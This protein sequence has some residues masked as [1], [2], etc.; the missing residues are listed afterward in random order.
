MLEFE[1]VAREDDFYSNT[2]KKAPHTMLTFDFLDFFE[3][4]RQFHGMIRD[5]KKKKLERC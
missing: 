1:E 2:Q 5:V 3:E 4:Q